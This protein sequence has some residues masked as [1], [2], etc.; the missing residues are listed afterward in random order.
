MKKIWLT[1]TTLRDGSHSV[2]HQYSIDQAVTIAKALDDAEID[3]IEISHGDGLAGSS[4]QYGFS[5]ATDNDLIKEVSGVIKNSKLAVLILPGI[6]TSADLEIARKYGAEVARVATHVTE[7]DV[8]QQHIKVAKSMGMKTVGFLM[9][10]HMAPVENLVEQ[11]KLM[12]SYGADI[13]YCTDS[14]GALLPDGVKERITALKENLSVD[15]GFHAH[16]NLNL[17]IGNSLAAIE[18]GATYVDCSLNGAGAGAGNART[19]SLVAV[20]KKSGY[21]TN[22]DLYKTLDTAEK[23]FRKIVPEAT[24]PNDLTLMLGYAGVY[25]SFLLHTYK[26]AEKFHV[27]PREILVEL[28]KRKVVGGQEDSIIEVAYE[29]SQKK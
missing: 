5:K 26:A 1:D 29:M 15:I 4:L 14:S 25:S 16:D 6:G 3:I 7:A 8:S 21:E 24:R 10:V 27:D 28:G 12:E 13:V 9:M 11:A 23:V 19:E 20:L 2:S 18:A 17:A 22:A